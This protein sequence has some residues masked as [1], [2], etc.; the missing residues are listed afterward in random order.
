M[1]LPLITIIYHQFRK[2]LESK[3]SLKKLQIKVADGWKLSVAN[4]GKIVSLEETD[5]AAELISAD[6]LG[7]DL[8]HEVFHNETVYFSAPAA[9]LGKKLTSYGGALSYS[10]FYTP[11]PFGELLFSP[12]NDFLA[13]Q[14]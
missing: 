4:L 3:Y 10:I 11:G 9:Y 1:P 2:H 14:F 12:S 5:V 6:N 8:T 13:L 7:A